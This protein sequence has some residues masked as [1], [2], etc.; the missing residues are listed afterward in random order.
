[1]SQGRPGM[2]D[3]NNKPECQLSSYVNGGLTGTI[4]EKLKRPAIV[5]DDAARFGWLNG[6]RDWKNIAGA[7]Q[8]FESTNM[9]NSH[10]REVFRRT[11][12]PVPDPSMVVKGLTTPG[13]SSFLTMVDRARLLSVEWPANA[14]LPSSLSTLGNQT[15]LPPRRMAYQCCVVLPDEEPILPPREV[16]VLATAS[17]VAFWL[18][19]GEAPAAIGRKFGRAAHSC[20]QHA[21]SAR[22]PARPGSIQGAAAAPYARFSD[23]TSYDGSQ[24]RN[25]IARRCRQTLLP[26][27]TWK[28]GDG[29]T[30]KQAIQDE[31]GLLFR[32]V[33]HDKENQ[34]KNRRPGRWLVRKGNS[35]IRRL[36]GWML[37]RRNPGKV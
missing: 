12:T 37:G 4:N 2:K 36:S 13:A 30:T 3:F 7:S 34:M 27:I 5:E 35:T 1:M 8:A 25:V 19:P 10:R 17:D 15:R 14:A 18:E 20:T 33:K 21:N 16:A 26:G 32:A 28:G 11:G 29:P 6:N 31:L 22:P 24:A 23:F 9:F